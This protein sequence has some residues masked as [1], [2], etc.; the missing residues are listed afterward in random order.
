MERK[1]IASLVNL[2]KVREYPSNYDIVYSPLLALSSIFTGGKKD[3]RKLCPLPFST[4][5][6]REES[7]EG[8]GTGSMQA[9][10]RGGKN[11]LILVLRWLGAVECGH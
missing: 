7:G 2:W 11:S 5:E 1:L 3:D 8:V 6:R 10:G 9:D 4:F